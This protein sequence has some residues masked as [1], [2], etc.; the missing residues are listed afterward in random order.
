MRM[1]KHQPARR[2]RVAGVKIPRLEARKNRS[3]IQQPFS[4][5]A[6][7]WAPSAQDGYSQP[8]VSWSIPTHLIT[9]RHLNISVLTQV[10]CQQRGQR[11]KVTIPKKLEES[12]KKGR[13]CLLLK[14]TDFLL[15]LRRLLLKSIQNSFSSI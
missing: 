13:F 4:A 8:C 14:G 6:P 5:T 7:T 10:G 2:P 11:D 12:A 15:P 3:T 1:R 9:E